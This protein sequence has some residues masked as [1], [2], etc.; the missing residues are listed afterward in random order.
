MIVTDELTENNAEDWP[1]LVWILDAR[2]E[3]QSVPIATCPMPPV[4]AYA[5]PR[6]PLRRA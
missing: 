2:D 6:R 5:R 4:D 1:K 3:K